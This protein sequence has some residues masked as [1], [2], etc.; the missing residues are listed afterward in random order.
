MEKAWKITQMDSA[1]NKIMGLGLSVG[2][3]A[4]RISMVKSH[5]IDR[6]ISA[7]CPLNGS[8]AGICQNWIKDKV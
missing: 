8:F 2:A 3:Y 5:R 6:D 7:L 1:P 4:T